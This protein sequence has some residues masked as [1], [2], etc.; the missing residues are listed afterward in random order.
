[1]NCPDNCPEEIYDLMIDCWAMN[2]EQR[3]TAGE[4]HTALQRWS[5]ALSASLQMA[6]AGTAQPQYQN[7][8]TVQEYAQ[9]GLSVGN[10]EEEEEEEEEGGGGQGV[11]VT[12][13]KGSPYLE[14]VRSHSVS[15][16]EEVKQPASDYDHLT[17]PGNMTS[18]PPGPPGQKGEPN[19]PHTAEG[20]GV[21]PSQN[22]VLVPA[23]ATAQGDPSL[24]PA[25]PVLQ[26]GQG[27]SSLPQ[28]D[29]EPVLF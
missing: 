13:E 18:A 12:S 20:T 27:Q 24:Q 21:P 14:P 15:V 1:M 11:V 19:L 3:P 16:Q 23:P 5:P 28:E 22:G 10:K 4:L 7:V 26:D 8:S 9:K 6:S 2:P 17:S 25:A 29:T